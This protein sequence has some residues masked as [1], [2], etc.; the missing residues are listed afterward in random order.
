MVE[1][2][3]AALIRAGACAVPNRPAAVVRVV[4]PDMPAIGRQE[5]IYGTVLV[6]VTVAADGAVSR[7]RIFRS[8]STILNAAALAAARASTYRPQLQNCVP[9]AGDAVFAASFRREAASPSAGISLSVSASGERLAVVRTYAVV[10]RPADRAMIDCDVITMGTDDAAAS[11]A[12][13]ATI[14]QIVR[15]TQGIATARIAAPLRAERTPLPVAT[16]NAPSPV[17]A[18]SGPSSPSPRAMVVRPLILHVERFDDIPR[19]LRILNDY[20]VSGVVYWSLRDPS[21]AQREAL[22]DAV[23]YARTRADAFARARGLRVVGVRR[24]TPETARPPFAEFSPASA[25]VRPPNVNV[26][27]GVSVTYVLGR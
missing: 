13:E 12:S 10:V 17:P 1:L 7:V 2:V 11:A 4:A 26:E 20:E 22:I 15:A 23:R 3:A 18:A 27:R 19:V 21:A 8:P 9:V 25:P 16:P 14:A 24:V 5:G 6:G